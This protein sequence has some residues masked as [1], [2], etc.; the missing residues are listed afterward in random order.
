MDNREQI[1]E[2]MR[3]KQY[4]SRVSHMEVDLETAAQL[5]VQ[6]F[7]RAWRKLHH[8]PEAQIH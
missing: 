1:K 6:K 3:Y 5:W 2:I 7:A 4:L 8:Y